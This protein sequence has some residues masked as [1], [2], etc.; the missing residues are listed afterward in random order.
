MN[1]EI[2][3][4]QDQF[5]LNNKPT[6]PGVEHDG[7]KVEGLLF[8]SRMVQAI[9]DDSNPN[10]VD[11]W[12]YPDTGMWDADRNVKEF[13]AVL[14]EYRK[15]GL[16]A[17]TVGLQGGGSIYRPEIYDNYVNSAYEPDGKFKPAYFERLY[18]IIQAADEVGMIVIVN[19]F[20]V[21][22]ARR[23]ESETVVRRVTEEVTDWLLQ[24]G[25]RNLLVDVANETADWWHVPYFQP[26]N[27]H[28]LIEIV[29]QTTAAGRR[30]LVGASTSG[31]EALPYGTWMEIED[32]HMPHGNGLKPEALR[33]KLHQLKQ[34]A[35]YQ[36]QPKPI[37]INEDSVF[38]E[39]LQIALEEYSSW[40]FY[41]QGFGSNYKDL[42][43]WTTQ[44]REK[45]Y[46]DLSGYQTIPVNWGINDPWKK[47]FFEYLKTITHSDNQV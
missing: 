18:R 26:E 21:K 27:I 14:P 42:M 10:T 9:F 29:Q 23:L 38:T 46:D 43:D 40:G 3:I 34:S 13:C 8:N 25:H 11:N 7:H 28:K 36:K 5:L 20:Y 44:D 15:H 41:H 37:L 47:A 39:N 16:L 1:N 30:L 22:H 12:R 35:S 19:Y 4:F 32:F 2:S 31:G 24:T 6:Y 33:S 45:K 17:V